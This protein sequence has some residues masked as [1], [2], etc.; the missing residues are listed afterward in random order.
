M[1]RDQRCNKPLLHRKEQGGV[2]RP[3]SAAKQRIGNSRKESTQNIKGHEA[4]RGTAR[5]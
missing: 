4:I 3:M 5:G 2:Y 1:V